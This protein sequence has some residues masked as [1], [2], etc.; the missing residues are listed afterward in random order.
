MT[1]DILQQILDIGISLT[2]E[3]DPNKLLAYIM[4]NA[5][6][7]TGAD[8]GTLYLLEGDVLKFRIMKTKSKG[9]DKGSDGEPIDIPA[10][11]LKKENVCAY[12]AISKTALNIEDVYNNEVFDFSGPKRYDAMNKYRTQSMIAIPMINN[13]GDVIGV[14]QLLNATDENGNVRAFSKDEERILLSLASQTAICLANMEYVKNLSKQMWSFTEAMTEAIDARTPYNGSHTRKVAE[15]SGKIVDRINA[16]HEE[17]KEDLSFSEEHREQV[18][19]AAFLHDIGK[20][21]V[22][23]DVMNKETRL[24]KYRKDIDARFENR[25]LKNEI[26]YLKNRCSE[27]DYIKEKEQLEKAVSLVA[28]VDSIGFIDDAKMAEIC[29]C[30]EYVFTDYETMEEYPFFDDTEKECMQVRKG[31]LTQAERT[32][33]E[34]HVV[35]TER[36][37]SKVYFNKSFSMAPIWAAQHHECI[38]NS[39]YPKKIGGNDLGP[40]ARILA[41]ADICDALL[42]TDRPYKKPLP[43]EKAFAI[44]ESMANEGKLEMK[45]VNYLREC[46]E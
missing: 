38:N 42:A 29:E 11:P 46:L 25:L 30:I 3:E 20:M 43:K 4:E 35:M 45:Y 7:L 12:S 21:I 2:A 39:G 8:G 37:L 41:V 13:E 14:M 33:M 17:G 26:N 31:T 23:I 19:M 18:V 10:V 5:M 34:N 16:L 6:E 1:K 44:M 24:G 9:F 27:A 32:I 22:P 36:I 40:E 15:Y 28:E